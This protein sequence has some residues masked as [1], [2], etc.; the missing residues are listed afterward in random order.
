[1]LKRA[2][3]YLEEE[4]SQARHKVEQARDQQRAALRQQQLGERRTD[5]EQQGSRKPEESSLP[6]RRNHWSRAYRG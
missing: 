6:F 2:P 1:M 4:Q 5:A 3:G